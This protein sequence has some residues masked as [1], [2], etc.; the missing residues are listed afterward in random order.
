MEKNKINRIGYIDS[1][2]GLCAIGVLL[3]HWACVFS[4]GLYFPDKATSLFD[5]VWRGSP[6]NVIT[7]GDI[8]VQFFFVCS[9]LLITQHI[10][11]R[12]TEKSVGRHIVLK[13]YTSLLW[14]IVPAVLF[15]YALM[16]LGLMYHNE[17][18]KLDDKFSFLIDFNQFQPSLIGAFADIGKTFVVGSSYNGLLWTM[19]HQLLGSLIITAC[20]SWINSSMTSPKDRK[21]AYIFVS[22]PFIYLDYYLAG[23]FFGALVFECYYSMQEDNEILGRLIREVI[24]NKVLKILVL[25][26]GLYLACINCTPLTGIYSWLSSLQRANPVIRATGIAIVLFIIMN[27]SKAQLLIDKDILRWFGGLSPYIYAFHWPV[28]LSLG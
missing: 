15:S 7:N 14:I 19:K 8:G 20:T 17:L 23:F 24:E 2:R 4:P 28:I 16:K 5:V 22:L 11:N 12:K 13:K 27:S 6:L 9:G 1:M 3:C 21:L 25:C 10:Y 18:L 26:I